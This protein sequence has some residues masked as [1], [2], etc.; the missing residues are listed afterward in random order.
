[1]LR[2]FAYQHFVPRV[3]F[4]VNL[5]VERYLRI[6]AVMLAYQHTNFAATVNHYRAATQ[7]MGIHGYQPNGIQ[8]RVHNRPSTTEGVSGRTCGRSNDN[9]IRALAGY[10]V[11]VH[12]DF[13][14]QHADELARMQ[15]HVIECIASAHQ[16]A[17][18]IHLP[19]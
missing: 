11:S 2:F 15:Y 8:R 18:V 7:S 19:S 16:L 10:E 9:A 5:A 13:K 1:M 12:V 3:G 17:P 6:G 14:L 4:K